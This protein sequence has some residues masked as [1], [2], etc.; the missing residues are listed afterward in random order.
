MKPNIRISTLT[1]LIKN[2][3]ENKLIKIILF[4]SQAKG[5]A[6]KDSDFDIAIIVDNIE[7]KEK[8]DFLNYLWW[9]SSK[10]GIS[11]DFIIKSN[12]DYENEKNLPTLSK[13]IDEEGE[14]IWQRN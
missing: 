4:G 10:A 8:I 11:A 6:Q 9:E 1:Y 12:S 2:K 13:V 5:T 14:I 3:L 7:R